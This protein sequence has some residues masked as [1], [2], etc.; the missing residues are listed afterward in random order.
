MLVEL[1]FLEGFP[2]EENGRYA[3]FDPKT[4]DSIFRLLLKAGYDHVDAMYIV[5]ARFSLSELV[6]SKRVDNKSYMDL[7]PDDNVSQHLAACRAH[8]IY[9]F[10]KM[11]GTYPDDQ[12]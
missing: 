9:D 1:D 7:S 5:L 4:F 12:L 11:G 6:L 8:F 10:V 3:V 2:K